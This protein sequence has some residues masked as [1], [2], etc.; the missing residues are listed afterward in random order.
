M[1]LKRR[2]NAPLVLRRGDV[3]I[4]S[5]DPTIGSEINKTR[6]GVVVSNNH[7]NKLSRT[8]M[9]MPITTGEYAYYHWITMKPPEGGLK[10]VSRIVTDQIRTIDKQR[11]QK[12][13]GKV[14]KK[15]LFAIEQSIRNSFALPEGDV[16]E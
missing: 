3:C 2:N 5:L 13:I 15:T 8:I 14:S 16:L 12:K 4:I 7:I 1:A 9:I 10:I 6:P 11:I